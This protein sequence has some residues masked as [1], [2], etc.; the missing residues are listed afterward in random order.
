MPDAS[1]P[2]PAT[3]RLRVYAF[4]PAASVSLDTAVINNAVIELPWEKDWEGGLEPGPANDYLD[5]HFPS[6]ALISLS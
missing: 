3:R 2:K 6:K 1:Y 5:P 4:D